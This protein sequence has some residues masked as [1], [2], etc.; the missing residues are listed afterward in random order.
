[1][2]DKEI[3]I[4]DASLLELHSILAFTQSV[5]SEPPPAWDAQT[6]AG[7]FGLWD[8]NRKQAALLMQCVKN[9]YRKRVKTI[10][11]ND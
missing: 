11:E 7:E 1:M 6:I 10:L 8:T 2:I 5:L 9:E 4:E 3:R